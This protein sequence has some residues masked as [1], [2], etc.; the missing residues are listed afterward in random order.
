MRNADS[1][2]VEVGSLLEHTSHCHIARVADKELQKVAFAFLH[3]SL[4][5]HAASYISGMEMF[6]LCHCNLLFALQL[7]AKRLP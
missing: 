3:L 5:V 2:V 6:I 1:K 4:I 7:M